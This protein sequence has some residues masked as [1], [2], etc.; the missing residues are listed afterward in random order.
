MKNEP[1]AGDTTMDEADQLIAWACELLE[2]NETPEATAWREAVDKFIA[3][4]TK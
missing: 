2:A 1:Q 3:N 4:N